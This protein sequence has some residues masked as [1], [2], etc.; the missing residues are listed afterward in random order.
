MTGA[1]KRCKALTE[2]TLPAL[3]TLTMVIVH[4][5][6]HDAEQLEACLVALVRTSKCLRGLS[7]IGGLREIDDETWT[8]IAQ[9]CTQLCSLNVMHVLIKDDILA[10]VARLCS[11]I[12]TIGMTGYSLLTD[13]V[14]Q[15]LVRELPNLREL[16]LRRCRLTDASLMYIGDHGAS[17]AEL[18]VGKDNL[19]KAAI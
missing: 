10:E 7:F 11:A 17:L 14:V 9:H 15:H 1:A 5:Y 4:D 12:H 13:T 18:S 16:R 3:Q 19:T 8:S 6:A 2:V